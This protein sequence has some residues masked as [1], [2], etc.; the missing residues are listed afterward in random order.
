MTISSNIAGKGGGL[1][2]TGRGTIGITSCSITGNSA[3][4]GGGLYNYQGT[5]TINGGTVNGN[6]GASGGGLFNTGRGT[7]G[8]TSCSITGNSAT[9]AGGGLY[10]GQGTVT[11]SGG[12]VS[13]NSGASGGG[14]FNTGRGTIGVT[15]CSVTGNSASGGGGGIYNDGGMA[16]LTAATVSGN[17]AGTGG[18]LF[19][20]GRGTIGMTSCTVGD[21]SAAA[22]GGLYND[23]AT[24]NLDA[25]T[26]G[27]NSAATGGGIDNLAGGGAT[28]EDTIVAANTGTG[29]APSDVVGDDSAGV[30]GTSDLVGSGGAGGLA[31]GTGD[32]VLSGG[33][34]PLLAPLGNYGG[35]TETMPLL[36]DSPA[37]D[38]GTAITGVT[39]DQRG[40]SLGA[41]PD[42]GAFQSQ[43]FIITAVAGSLDAGAGDAFTDP[44]AVTVTAVDPVDPVAGGVVNFSVIPASNGASASLSATTAIIGSDGVAQVNATANSVIGSY[45]LS[46][47]TVGASSPASITL[48][49]LVPLAFSGID[50]QSIPFGTASATFSGNIANGV[51]IPQ[52]E[53]VAVTLDGVTQQAAIGSLGAF[54]T[55]FDTAGLAASATPYAVSYAYTSDGTFADTSTTSALTVNKATPTIGWANPAQITYGTALSTTQL[56]ATGSVPGTL[57]YTPAL[58]T[59][60][61]SGPGQVPFGHVHAD[62]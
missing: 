22:G 39:N 10:N 9:G 20:T 15:G 31:G 23:D 50:S 6:T 46:V 26:I 28:L 52:G 2:N 7:I 1:F 21:N 51:Q 30:V 5:V 29:G 3:T 61:T 55:T 48:N 27:G 25:C 49:N 17:M 53:Y 18:G 62:R 47:S 42:I 58:G 56:D 40:V 35:A 24:A 12:T 13:G 59:V 19:N 38:T 32:I 11:L 44:L 14:L 57:T 37:I 33:S 16:T 41:T 8:I 34:S 54:F 45:T 43:G 4:N 36:P 60:L